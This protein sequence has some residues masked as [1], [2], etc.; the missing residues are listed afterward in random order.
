VFRRLFNRIYWAFA[1]PAVRRLEGRIDVQA[2]RLHD[3][4]R[5][6]EIDIRRMRVDLDDLTITT[7]GHM[8]VTRELM[9]RVGVVEDPPR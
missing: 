4:F 2:N 3:A 7:D 5:D 8:Q 6:Q 9:L 1:G